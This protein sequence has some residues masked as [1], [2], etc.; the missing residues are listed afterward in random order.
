MKKKI[1]VK[2]GFY[3]KDKNDVCTTDSNLKNYDK[4]ELQALKPEIS[5]VINGLESYGILTSGDLILK[6]DNYKIN[7]VY[8]FLKAKNKLK[9]NSKIKIQI[10]RNQKIL[11]FKLEI[12]S[13]E[14]WKK[15]RPVVGI[16]VKN[17]KGK[18]VVSKIGV[19]SSALPEF[20][21]DTTIKKD[22]VLVSV[23]NHDIKKI[24]DFNQALQDCIPGRIIN[25]KFLRDEI[26]MD[27]DIRIISFNE[28][29]KLNRKF[30]KQY[31]PKAVSGILVKEYEENDFYLNENYKTK[32]LN[33]H[34]K[35]KRNL[36][37]L[38]EKAYRKG[39][40]KIKNKKLKINI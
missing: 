29:I 31:W 40:I 5:L 13:F 21:S 14:N 38:I 33:P 39:R 34:W 15:R 17:I 20:L 35:S 9:W 27:V 3:F 25:I 4:K 6:L 30:C 11:D 22:D 10:K 28:F 2:L 24:K 18:I 7:N 1:S 23:D 8:D 19:M 16:T 37:K 26:L 36:S 12:K 32:M